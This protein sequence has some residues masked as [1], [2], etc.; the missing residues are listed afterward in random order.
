MDAFDAGMLTVRLVVGVVIAMHGLNKVLGPGGLVG[1]AGWFEALGM[2]RS[3]MQA[4]LA[5]GAELT[6]GAALVAG[7]ATPLACSAV[8]AL[9]TVAIV[10]VHGRNGFFIFRP[11]GGWEYCFVLASVAVVI[12]MLGPGSIS[13]DDVLGFAPAPAASAAVAAGGVVAATLQL[14]SSYRP[15]TGEPR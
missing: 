6:S 7:L 2:R 3:M 13:L 14:W 12:A 15:V 9:M 10:T 11:G 8:V 4:R 1:T 5:A